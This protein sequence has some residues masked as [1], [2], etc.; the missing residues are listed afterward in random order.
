MALIDIDG[1]LI[2]AYV[3]LGLGLDTAYEGQ[4][5]TPPDDGSDWA[6]VFIL[7]ATSDFFT[8]GENG[9]DQHLG[10]MQI[11][12]NTPHG[13][14]REALVDYAE[15]IRAEFIGGKGYIRNSQR[16]RIDTV[17]R[18]AVIEV[19]GWMRI[20]VSVNWEA[21]TIRPAI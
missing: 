15:Q 7:P 5:F 3:D 8:L 21:T 6:A 9:E 4:E 13:K 2:Q 20:S 16:V 19:D 1:A 12:F 10:L 11:D 17:E 18:T 14:G